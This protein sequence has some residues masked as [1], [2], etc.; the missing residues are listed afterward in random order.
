MGH[1]E[2]ENGNRVKLSDNNYK[3]I[4]NG[5]PD[6][7]DSITCVWTTISGYE[8]MPDYVEITGAEDLEDGDVITLTYTSVYSTPVRY[9]ERM[10]NPITAENPI[11]W[12]YVR[13]GLKYD[14]YYRT[15]GINITLS[16]NDGNGVVVTASASIFE[17]NMV[18][19][20]IRYIDSD[21]NVLGEGIITARNSATAVNIKVTTYFQSLTITGGQWGISTD[22]LS[23]LTHLNGREVQVFADGKE[24]ASKVVDSGSIDIDDA[25][26]AVV[27]LPYTSYITTMPMEAG[28]QNGTAVGKRKRIS[29]MAIR[30][31]NT[32]GV[33]VGRDFDNLY[34]TIYEQQEPF[35][36]VIPNIKYNQ[37]WV[38]DAN[39][40]VEQSHPYPMNIL[41]IAPIVTEV[42]K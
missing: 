6:N 14:G 31:W 34:D 29:E 32:I 15:R 5:I 27:G 35:T 22:V 3:I 42:D 26:I 16:A 2:T 33:R 38:W 12:W 21:Y 13:S 41:S 9:I 37:G 28:S 23:G 36:G 20:R 18:G 1:Y 4:L 11:D 25:F 17:N 10:M 24:Q 7:N 39:I 19:N 40:T 8:P 30:V